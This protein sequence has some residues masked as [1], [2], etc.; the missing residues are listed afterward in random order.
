MSPRLTPRTASPGSRSAFP[1][2]FGMNSLP[3][4]R[5]QIPALSTPAHERKFPR[6][7]IENEEFRWLYDHFC[8]KNYS[9]RLQI[10]GIIFFGRS[11]LQ[12]LVQKLLEFEILC[13]QTIE[14][15]NHHEIESL[16]PLLLYRPDPFRKAANFFFPKLFAYF[17]IELPQLHLLMNRE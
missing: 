3:E 17:W 4:K 7:L 15:R 9:R 13:F 10:S 16:L 8:Q 6:V 1:R 14:S 11:A 2:T 12:L 5:A